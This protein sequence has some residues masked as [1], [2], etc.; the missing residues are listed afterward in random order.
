LIDNVIW[1]LHAFERHGEAI[2]A[3]FT[4]VLA[5]STIAL[6][7]QTRNLHKSGE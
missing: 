5:L 2:I 3:F 4:I 1:C 7:W 6:W